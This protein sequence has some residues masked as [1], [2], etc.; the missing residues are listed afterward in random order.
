MVFKVE[1]QGQGRYIQGQI[2]EWVIAAGGD[3]H[4]DASALKYH[5]LR[6]RLASSGIVSLG[7]RHAVCVSTAFVSATKVMRRLSA[8]LHYTD[9]G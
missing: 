8:K 4:I 1:G 7:V 9:T 2:F 6:R 3:I 5:Y